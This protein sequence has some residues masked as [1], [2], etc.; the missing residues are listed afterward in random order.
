M[1]HFELKGQVRETGNKAVIK[2]TRKAGLVPCNLYGQ[3]MDNVLFTVSAKELKGLT[4]T[5]N[6]YIVDIVLD[7]G[8]KYLGVIHELQFHPVTDETL[9]V[10]FLAVKMDK[11]VCV[12][13]PLSFTGHAA[14]VRLGG[15]LVINQRKIRVSG[16]ADQLPDEV[17]IDVTPLNIGKDI[18]AGDVQIENATVVSPKATI[19]CAVKA[20]RQ[21]TGAAAGE[22]E[23]AE[24][25]AE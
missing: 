11:P 23:A 8:Q 5:P 14:G 1:K 20:T 15:K 10:D 16:L 13:V 18:K 25:A 7:N 9:H 19:L 21:S 3:G 22:E 6:S 24:P 17:T 4:H 12:D 2:A